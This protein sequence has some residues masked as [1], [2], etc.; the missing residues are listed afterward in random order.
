MSSSLKQLEEFSQDFYS[1]PSVERIL[2]ICLNGSVPL[3]K[4]TAMP[5]YS[6]DTLESFSPEQRKL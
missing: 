2:T 1:G 3:N 4:M 6:K 5:I